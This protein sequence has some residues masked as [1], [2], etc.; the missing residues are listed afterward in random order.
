[1]EDI[2]VVI[3]SVVFGFFLLMGVMVV[4]LN[5]VCVLMLVNLLVMNE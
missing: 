2:I 3:M 4:M 1:M 5:G